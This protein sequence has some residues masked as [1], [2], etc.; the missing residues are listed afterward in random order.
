[1]D[2]MDGESGLLCWTRAANVDS[3]G[4]WTE[5]GRRVGV[6]IHGPSVNRICVRVVWIARPR[7]TV[8]DQLDHNLLVSLA[9]A[10]GQTIVA[11]SRQTSS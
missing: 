11:P 3:R 2:K 1:M 7:R 10:L 4:Q 9:P 8:A 5:D 6:V